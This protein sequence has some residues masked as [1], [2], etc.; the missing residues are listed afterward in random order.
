[1]PFCLIHQNDMIPKEQA[2]I[3][4]IVLEGNKIVSPETYKQ[5]KDANPIGI[6]IVPYSSSPDGKIR[7]IGLDYMTNST[8]EGSRDP[9]TVPIWGI[10]KAIPG[11]SYKQQLPIISSESLVPTDKIVNH[12][13]NG[14]I[15]LS[16]DMSQNSKSASTVEGYYYNKTLL[17]S[18]YYKYLV[19]NAVLEDEKPNPLYR[20]TSYINENGVKVTI[21]NPLADFD[22]KKNT[23]LILK[24]DNKS[25]TEYPGGKTDFIAAKMCTLYNKGGLSWY[26]PACGELGY[27]VCNL[28][29]INDSREV[30]GL[31]PIP[32]VLN[33]DST[34]IRLWSSTIYSTSGANC[35]HTHDGYVGGSVNRTTNTKHHC[36]PAAAI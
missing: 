12:N 24:V 27:L 28:K 23:D 19:P 21:S 35:I 15:P 20:A 32:P 13:N 34:P 18:K 3:G 1:M 16:E 6:V 17:D 2:K 9:I 11:L 36:L 33:G 8:T 25:E 30:I 14:A 22:G 7:M 10:N 29:K 31:D 4:D 5:L 26:L